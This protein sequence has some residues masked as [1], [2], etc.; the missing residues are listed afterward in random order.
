M[1]LLL[2]QH[3]KCQRWAIKA[4]LTIVGY[5]VPK[6][7]AHPEK[8]KNARNCHCTTI[9]IIIGCNDFGFLADNRTTGQRQ[10]TFM[11]Q[12]RSVWNDFRFYDATCIRDRAGPRT[13][14]NTPDLCFGMQLCSHVGFGFFSLYFFCLAYRISLAKLAASC[15]N[16]FESRK[17][18]SYIFVFI[19]FLAK[20]LPRPTPHSTHCL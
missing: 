6:M 2:Q 3:L 7:R 15:K 1:S 20:Q 13:G 14:P 5:I 11:A 10:P 16:V 9:G 8:N 12:T 19:K 17:S 18:I 4:L